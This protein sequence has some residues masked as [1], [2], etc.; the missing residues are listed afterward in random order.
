MQNRQTIENDTQTIVE[1]MTIN[2]KNME[3]RLEE[4]I[5]KLK[6]ENAS[7]EKD[8]EVLED[9]IS[10]LKKE[11]EQEIEKQDQRIKE[12]NRRINEMSTEFAEMLKGLLVKMEDRI[13]FANKDWQ[14]EA[15]GE[16]TKKFD[17]LT[18]INN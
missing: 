4:E 15:S 8:I 18:N 10:R 12:L 14:E 7:E 3:T 2:Y 13:E 16:V 1:R 17:H 6:G 5:Q 11:R 9:D